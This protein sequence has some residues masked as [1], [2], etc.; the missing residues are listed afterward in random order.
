MISGI[1]Q[2]RNIENGHCY[3]GSAVNFKKRKN[4]HLHELEHNK[5]HS[6]HLQNAYNKYGRDVFVFE[7]LE[8][9]ENEKLIE[10]EQF[11]MDLLQPEYNIAPKA[12]SALGIKRTIETRTKIGNAN[13]NPS[14]E[15]LAR[16]SNA[17][18][19]PSQETRLKIS[20]SL[21][22]KKHSTERRANI[23][24]GRKNP[25]AETRAKLSAARTGM[26]YSSETRAKMSASGRAT[27]QARKLLTEFYEA[28]LASEVA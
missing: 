25:S 7:I 24:T 5:H 27:W 21:I 19:N 17:K 2:I 28:Q 8:Y 4:K 12:G 16:M 14:P 10:R 6:R 22:G 1:Y 18:K 23:S 15:T 3:I 20:R 13:R 9:C 26:K 11:F